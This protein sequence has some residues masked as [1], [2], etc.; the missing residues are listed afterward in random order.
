[1][2]IDTEE[3]RNKG[4][5][6]NNRYHKSSHK[7]KYVSR[8]MPHILPSKLVKLEVI[9]FKTPLRVYA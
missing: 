8:A 6:G 2:M 5:T 4:Y 7:I 3:D 1:M 9:E